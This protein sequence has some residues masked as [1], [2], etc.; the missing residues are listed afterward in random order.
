MDSK[1]KVDKTDFNV[2]KFWNLQQG[3][4][5]TEFY[6]LL[7]LDPDLWVDNRD[8]TYNFGPQNFIDLI[9]H[10]TILL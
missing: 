5:L 9:E 3:L 4:A 7:Y 6:R 8:L 1:K 10:E 2:H